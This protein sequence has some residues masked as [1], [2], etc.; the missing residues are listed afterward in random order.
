MIVYGTD[1][2]RSVLQ[3]LKQRSGGDLSGVVDAVRDIVNNV[4]QRGDV[5]LLDYALRFENTDYSITPLRIAGDEIDAAYASCTQEQIDALRLA[6]SRLRAYHE[7]QIETG[8]TIGENGRLL[9]QIVRPIKRVGIYAPGGTASYPSS[10]LMNAVPAKVAGVEQ[11]YLATPAQNGVISPLMLV[12]AKIAGVDGIFRMGGAQA[13]A[14]FAYGTETVPK[15]DK[16]TGPGNRYVAAAKREVFGTVGIDTIA[17]PSEV[18]IL[19]DE[20]ADPRYVAADMLAQAE[21][22][23]TA[24]AICVTTSKELALRVEEDIKQQ[25]VKAQRRNIIDASLRTYGAIVVLEDMQ[26]CLDLVNDIAPEHLEIHTRD[27]MDLLPKIQNAGGV[28]IGPYTP[29]AL[30]DYIAGSNHVLPTNG[31]ARFASPLGVYDFIKRMSA[32]AFDQEG[33]NEVKGA[34]VSLAEA[35]GLPAHG[36]SASIRFEKEMK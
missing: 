6:A 22:D 4:R 27:G 20:W 3:R 35:E 32:L 23:T 5:A 7:K 14:A 28:F 1:G 34:I 10:V 8:Y 9:M 26:A 13:V 36:K 25:C 17:G 33:L 31:T 29:E 16:I 19:A 24:A 21:H 11:I 12:A 15:V 2:V 18:V 30:G